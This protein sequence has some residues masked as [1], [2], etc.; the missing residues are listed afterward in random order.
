[1]G[2]IKGVPGTPG[3]ATMTSKQ[4]QIGMLATPS[5]QAELKR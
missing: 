4:A 3:G 1:V 5:F 2:P